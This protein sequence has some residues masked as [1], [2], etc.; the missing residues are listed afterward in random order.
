MEAKNHQNLLQPLLRT[1][2]SDDDHR[3]EQIHNNNHTV[4]LVSSSNLNIALR[5]SLV[6][7]IGFVSI[8]ANHEASKGFDITIVNESKDT[9]S[10]GKRFELFYV[11]NDEATRLVLRTSKLVEDYLYPDDNSHQD[12]GHDILVPSKK[13]VNHVILN[14]K[15]PNSTIR[16]NRDHVVVEPGRDHEFVVKISPY[17]MDGS[18]FR[19]AVFLA[20]QRGM[21]RVWLWDGLGNA[22]EH[23]MNG[24]VEYVTGQIVGLSDPRDNRSDL[25]ATVDC[26]RH[27]ESVAVA[28]FLD[29]CERRRPGFVRRLNQAMKDGWRDAD[30]DDALGMPTRNLCTTYN[31]LRYNH[32]RV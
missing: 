23:L 21:V 5:L 16:I 6:V 17:V 11:Q 10:S 19:N 30:L 9:S 13:K 15:S 4:N 18:D 20:V 12:Y 32:S 1:S 26:W 28:E 3:H 2:T 8:W 7:F 31:S 22:P 25:S 14:L 29:Y 27:D 24:M